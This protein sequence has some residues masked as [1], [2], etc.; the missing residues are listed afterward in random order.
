MILP[1]QAQLLLK[2][3]DQFQELSDYLLT[4]SQQHARIDRVERGLF[5]LLLALGRTLLE[6]FIAG[7]GGGD[8][9]PQVSWGDRTLKR[10]EELHRRWYRSIFGKLAIWRWVYAPGLKKKIEQVPTDAQLGLPRGEYSYVLEDWLE[11]LCVKEAF[12]EGVDGLETL[13]GIEASVRTAE[14]QNRQMAEFAEG[15]RLQQPAPPASEEETILVATAD[16]TSVPIRAVDRRPQPA[17]KKSL[18]GDSHPGTTRR[19]Y[20]G[21]VYSIAAF[22]REPKDVWDELFRNEAAPRRPRPQGKRLWTEMA[23]TENGKNH[24]SERVFIELAFDV[25]HRDPDRQK[26]LVCLMD[27]EHKLWDLQQSW[28]GRSVQILDFFHVLERVREMSKLVEPD[29][30]LRREVWVSDQVRDLLEGRV[31]SVLRRWRRLRRLAKTWLKSQRETLESA[32]GYYTNNCQRMQYDVY[33]AKGYPIGSGVAEGACRHLVKDRMDG[34][35]MHWR[36]AGARAMLKT[37]ALYLNGE[38]DE[39]VE[40]R[41]QQEQQTLYQTAA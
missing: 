4:Q 13:L 41:I 14:E 36:L 9:G 39:F 21:A 38:W 18:E 31:E 1:T 19:A 6:A 22:V 37:R 30:P 11:R 25:R 17:G 12:A 24:G 20:I 16:G 10:S 27:G 5:S 3:H 40:Y 15:F 26:T 33:L 29:S 28:L 32:I 35:G 2:A 23:E 7:A 8:A 34:T